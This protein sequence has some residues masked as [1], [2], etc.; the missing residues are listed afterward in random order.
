MVNRYVK[1]LLTLDCKDDLLNDFKILKSV[2]PE[3]I[4][5]NCI[6]SRKDI[7]A[8]LSKYFSNTFIH[9]FKSIKNI[10][11]IPHILDEFRRRIL[12]IKKIT[13][14]T[15]KKINYIHSDDSTEIEYVIL[16]SIIGG[17]ILIDERSRIIDR[18]YSFLNYLYER[19]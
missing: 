1:A 13:L 8:I 4:K 18:S 6:L 11:Y 10:K 12:G 5:L 16:P 2:F 19:A 15:A 3:I 14:I 9:L 17:W 7:V